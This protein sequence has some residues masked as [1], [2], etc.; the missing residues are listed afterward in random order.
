MDICSHRDTFVFWRL[1]RG[2]KD[3]SAGMERGFDYRVAA[4]TNCILLAPKHGAVGWQCSSVTIV[5]VFGCKGYL[6][7]SALFETDIIA[8]LVG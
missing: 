1:L 3:A 2:S 6:N 4:H 8:M 7:L 5:W